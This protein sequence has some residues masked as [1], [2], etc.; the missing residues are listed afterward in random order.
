MGFE[1]AGSVA[2]MALLAQVVLGCGGTTSTP[3]GSAGLDA[4]GTPNGVGGSAGAPAKAGAPS[5]GNASSGSG[6]QPSAG[7]PPI[8]VNEADPDQPCTQDPLV[9]NWRDERLDMSGQDAAG[10]ELGAGGPLAI[11]VTPGANGLVARVSREGGAWSEPRPL[12]GTEAEHYPARVGVSADGSTALVLSR[13]DQLVWVN[14]RQADGSFGPASELAGLPPDADVLVLPGQR[15]LFGYGGGDGI[16]LLEYTAGGSLLEVAPILANYDGLFRDGA[17]GLL[18]FAGTSVVGGPDAAYPYAFGGGFAEKQLLSPRLVMPSASQTF[19]YAFPNGRGARVIR[20]WLDEAT[21]GLHVTTRQ[22]G[23]WG[24]EELVS[25]FDGS[26]T[27]KPA[28]AYSQNG[29]LLAWQDDTADHAVAR[30][31][32]GQTWQVE[33]VLP[34]SR[35]LQIRNLV[36][37][38]S[39]ALLLGEQNIQDEG[40]SAQKLYR[41]GADG[42]WYCAKLMPNGFGNAVISDG[43]GFWFAERVRDSLYISHF[44]P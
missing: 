43:T 11:V 1:G 37:A 6:G 15:V 42:T 18:V 23:A 34:R 8:V 17:E 35:A 2:A 13:R 21:R 38:E 28:L 14:F 19:F 41:R 12:P 4:G 30:E 10:F 25:R 44:S 33:Q 27:S 32:D 26:A 5:G 3:L 40:V 29:V 36:G 39:S 22:Q 16:H 9:E 7:E 20:T 31:H 24:D